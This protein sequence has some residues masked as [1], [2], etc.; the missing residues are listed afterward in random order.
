VKYG[1][2]YTYRTETGEAE[3]IPHTS[4]PSR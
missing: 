3:I 2:E 4:G 1:R